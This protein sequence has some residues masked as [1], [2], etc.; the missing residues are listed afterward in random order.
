MPKKLQVKI[1]DSV[2]EATFLEK[3]APVTCATILKHL[4]YEG[5]G[6]PV[7]WSGEAIYVNWNMGEKLA[8]ENETIYGSAGDI[9]WQVVDNDEFFVANGPAQYRWKSGPLLSNLFARI[10]DN[11]EELDRVC[12][13]IRQKG[14][15][16]VSL[17]AI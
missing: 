2:F 7:R 17:K 15:K 11:L 10:T 16:K 13:E 3:L 12:N 1:G 5:E 9:A 8:K 4:P 14:A 6:L